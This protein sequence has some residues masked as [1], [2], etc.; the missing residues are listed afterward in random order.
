MT[1]PIEVTHPKLGDML[2]WWCNTPLR[3]ET[4][5]LDIVSDV[6]QLC[7]KYLRSLDYTFPKIKKTGRNEPCPC[8]SGKKY[9]KCHGR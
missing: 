9:K 6:D 7:K 5:N 1:S 3:H 2:K 8:D 4:L